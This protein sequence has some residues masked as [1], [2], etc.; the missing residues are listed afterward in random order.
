VQAIMLFSHFKLFVVLVA[1]G[2]SPLQSILDIKYSF[3]DCLGIAAIPLSIDYDKDTGLSQAETDNKQ[4]LD[5]ATSEGEF[6][7]NS[8][9]TDVFVVTNIRIVADRQVQKM[10]EGFDKYK[11][12]DANAKK[13]YEAAFGEEGVNVKAD[14]V[15]GVITK[16]QNGQVRAEVGTAPFND[17][18]ASTPW[19]KKDKKTDGVDTPWTP[20]NLQTSAQFH[21]ILYLMIK[22]PCLSVS[23]DKARMD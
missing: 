4:R 8:Y 16:L 21:G 18:I 9:T 22:C 3:P 14:K 6:C 1:V 15:D 2:G 7:S 17:K 20:G 19:E 23:Q 5:A 11:N 12:G 13:Y 10:R